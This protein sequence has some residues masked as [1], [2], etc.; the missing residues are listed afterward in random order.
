MVETCTSQ[1]TLSVEILGPAPPK[2][3]RRTLVHRV[4][5]L[6]REGLDTTQQATGK[7]IPGRYADTIKLPFEEIKR[8]GM[9]RELSLYD[10]L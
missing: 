3:H 10:R 2:K 8:Q 5:L 7:A 1:E 6:F 9:L 4:P